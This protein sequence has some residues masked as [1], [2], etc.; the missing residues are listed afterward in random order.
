MKFNQ[1]ALAVLAA[2]GV[3]STTASA[4][5]IQFSN[6]ITKLDKKATFSV[7][8]ILDNQQASESE[9]VA[10]INQLMKKVKFAKDVQS[11]QLKE[12]EESVQRIG[13]GMTCG[14]YNL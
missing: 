12:V 8:L 7:Q 1:N 6:E 11:L 9:K 2:A 13:Q 10:Q 4:N 14:D 3:A 5:P